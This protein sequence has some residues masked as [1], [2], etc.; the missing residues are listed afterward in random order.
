M[1]MRAV[2]AQVAY[3]S[4]VSRRRGQGLKRIVAE[5][6]QS[7][8]DRNS[9]AHL[10]H[11]K[12]H[13]HVYEKYR[14]CLPEQC[15]DQIKQYVD[16]TPNHRKELAIDLGC[17]TGQSTRIFA[18][19]Y[20]RTLGW[21][22]AQTQIEKARETEQRLKQNI[23]YDCKSDADLEDFEHQSVDFLTVTEA[24]HYFNHSQF[25]ERASRVLKP[26]SGIFCAIGYSYPRFDNPKAAEYFN[27][28]YREIVGPYW[29]DVVSFLD[30]LYATIP[31]P[32]EDKFTR[33]ERFGFQLPGSY[34]AHEAAQLVRTW[35]AWNQLCQ[36]RGSEVGEQVLKDIEDTF[37]PLA[38][39]DGG[40]LTYQLPWFGFMA[41]LK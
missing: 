22:I 12:D 6:S 26:G 27:H 18:D 36:D 10:F 2:R 15:L 31:M 1:T 11:G 33:I 7:A 23:V 41:T 16:N 38:T 25:Y 35:S 21:D 9:Y 13:S 24:F 32:P 19:F 39:A 4:L 34:K 17:G 37:M 20:S 3:V 8:G 28:L 29:V 30:D 40:S 14:L 5:M